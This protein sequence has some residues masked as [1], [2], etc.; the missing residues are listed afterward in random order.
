MSGYAHLAGHRMMETVW[1]ERQRKAA[2][3]CR[4][5]EEPQTGR[6][7]C[8]KEYQFKSFFFF[9]SLVSDHFHTN[10]INAGVIKLMQQCSPAQWGVLLSPHYTW[11]PSSEKVYIA[12]ITL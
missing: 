4:D 8:K 7:W 6:Q 9:T 5:T 10:T 1:A 3:F 11:D 2:L 12:H